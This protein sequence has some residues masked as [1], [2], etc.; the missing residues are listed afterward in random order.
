MTRRAAL[1]ATLV[2]LA[3][4]TACTLGGPGDPS[5]AVAANATV[6]RIVDGDTIAVRVDGAEEDV[7]LIGIDTPETVDRNRPVMCFGE[8]ASARLGE[9]TPPGTAVRLE[10]DVEARDR[11]GRLLAYLYRASDGL[12]VNLAMVAE[13]LADQYTFPPNVEHTEELR[14]A[15]AQARDEGRGVWSACDAPF[16]S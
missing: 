16:A 11:Y 8:E 12:F 7:R 15:A 3:G 2:V 9:L 5:D 13:G 10:R 14:E 1:A 6:T 4:T